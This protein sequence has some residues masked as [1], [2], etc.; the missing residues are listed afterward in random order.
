MGG[1]S[2]RTYSNESSA[3]R[4]G[5]PRGYRVVASGMPP[6]DVGLR[7]RRLAR[8]AGCWARPTRH[9][10][11]RLA[12]YSTVHY[13]NVC[14]YISTRRCVPAAARLSTVRRGHRKP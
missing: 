6:C 8:R 13:A 11:A 3:R 12:A 7:L 2:P 5:L 14:I 10:R 1:V 4:G 9:G